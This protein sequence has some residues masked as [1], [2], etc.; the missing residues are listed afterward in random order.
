MSSSFIHSS[1]QSEN[2]IFNPKKEPSLQQPIIKINL[3]PKE[4]SDIIV[5]TPE[6]IKYSFYGNQREPNITINKTQYIIN[7]LYIWKG[8]IHN[9]TGVYY[10]GELIIETSNGNQK[11]F[12]C[13]LLKHSYTVTEPTIIDKLWS[14]ETPVLFDLEKEL[15]KI[16]KD[17]I[18]Y[19]NGIN[20]I[21]VPLTPIYINSVLKTQLPYPKC[22]IFTNFS[23]DYTIVKYKFETI[24]S[25][26]IQTIQDSNASY[27][28]GFE[29]FKNDK[30]NEDINKFSDSVTKMFTPT[31]NTTISSKVI[32]KNTETDT[33]A[34]DPSIIATSLQEKG[35]YL[36]CAP[37]SQ[38]TKTLPSITLP[39]D[40]NG[41]V[42]LSNSL[43]YSSIMNSLILFM[44][45]IFVCLSLPNIYKFTI[46]DVINRI[47]VPD[48]ATRLTTVSYFIVLII[49]IM[50]IALVV[51]G[52]NNG[53]VYEAY[54][55]LLIGIMLFSGLFRLYLLKNSKDYSFQQVYNWS[56]SDFPVW[57]NEIYY[58]FMDNSNTIGTIYLII[59]IIAIVPFLIP[60]LVI[61][62]TFIP[63][64]D[65]FIHVLSVILG[66]AFSYNIILAPFLYLLYDAYSIKPQ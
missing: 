57:L 63:S 21:I 42:N 15:S 50:M 39:L 36:D 10:D 25:Q 29:K 43:L 32:K 53:N 3:P 20:T 48:K 41:N 6:Y 26:T 22:F 61:P 4:I 16:E 60:S 23:N 34:F 58:Y 14:S 62:D 64:N 35:L 28:E 56:F 49:G 24:T 18:Y 54:G 17:A 13:F 40:I 65:K 2:S 33:L 19:K 5:K 55:G 38:S 59:C 47:N 1:K 37:T 31:T 30:F 8:K 46:V 44:I 66:F 9:I 11:T 51:D 52:L 12:L 45:I 7:N 27:I